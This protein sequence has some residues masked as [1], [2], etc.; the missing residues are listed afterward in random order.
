MKGRAAPP[1]THKEATRRAALV[2]LDVPGLR[3]WAKRYAVGLL[4][5]DRTVLISIHEARVVDLT[6][7]EQAQ[8]ESAAWLR[9]EYPESAVLRLIAEQGKVIC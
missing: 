3:A 2:A 4:G 5:D 1:H 6:L 8:Q 7:P 9:R